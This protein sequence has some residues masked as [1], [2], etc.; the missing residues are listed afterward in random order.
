MQWPFAH[1][2]TYAELMHAFKFASMLPTVEQG[3]HVV[4]E[5]R[6]ILMSGSVDAWVPAPKRPNLWRK[7]NTSR[8]QRISTS[9]VMAAGDSQGGNAAEGAYQTIEAPSLLE[10]GTYPAKAECSVRSTAYGVHL[11]RLHAKRHSC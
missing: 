3:G 4:L 8:F 1:G 5:E 6:A 10:P 2:A 7:G 11:C 9:P